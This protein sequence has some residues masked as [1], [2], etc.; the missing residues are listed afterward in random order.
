MAG[1][2]QE[3]K[4][5]RDPALSAA[6]PPTNA[7]GAKQMETVPSTS[8]SA[9]PAGQDAGDL[10]L[11]GRL[12]GQYRILERLGAGGMGQVYKAMHL[13]MERVV[14]LKIISPRLMQD[15]SVCARFQREVRNAARLIHPNI[16]VAHDAAQVEG[17]WFLVMEHIEGRDVSRLL[18]RHSR[19]SVGLACEIVRQAALGLQCAHECGMVHRDI[20]PAN[21]M[22]ASARPLPAGSG[23]EGWPDAPLVKILDFGLARLTAPDSAGLAPG[24]GLTREGYMVGTPEYMAPEQARDSRLVDI[25]S[26]IYSLGCT[27]YTLLAGRPPFKAVSAFELAVLHM[28]QPPE[29]IVRHN[30]ALPLDLSILVHRMMAKLPEG[31][32]QTPGEAA[33]ALRPWARLTS[34]PSA[35]PLSVSVPGLSPAP[36]KSDAPPIV[37]SSPL[38]PSAQPATARP[39]YKEPTIPPGVVMMQFQ[40]LLRT[41]LIAT[42]VAVVGIG[43]VLYLPDIGNTVLQLWQRLTPHTTKSAPSR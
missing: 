3:Q 31:R 18:S 29:P 2:E 9:S 35:Q 6:E 43:C 34:I 22:V 27:L 33:R 20:K 16:V 42:I 23:A 32:F 19:P 5:A 26:D 7:Y 28:N 10:F 37:A 21:L 13:V 36:P 11:P 24:D 38:S 12:L 8:G 41:I 14:A 30:P 1:N 4:V 40:A 17:L 25:R 15:S 39:T